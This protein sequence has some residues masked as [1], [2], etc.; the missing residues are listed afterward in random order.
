MK[1]I[2]EIEDHAFSGIIEYI[3][4][5]FVVIGNGTGN[6]LN[7]GNRNFIVTC[8]HIA[9]QFFNSGRTYVVLRDNVRISLKNMKLLLVTEDDLDIALIEILGEFHSRGVYSL[10]DLLIIEDFAKYD[11]ENTYLVICGLPGDLVQRDRSGDFHH[12]YLSFLTI[13]HKSMKHSENFIYVDYSMKKEMIEIQSKS[14]INLPK[15]PGL[16]GS[17]I[18]KIGQFD[19]QKKELWLPST[20]FLNY[21]CI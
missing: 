12:F 4:D 20:A 8:K 13:P 6:L 16:S 14:K 3:R 18:L 9:E 19:S 10:N 21:Y 1:N 11:W 5:R 7:V 2:E 15:A 17:F